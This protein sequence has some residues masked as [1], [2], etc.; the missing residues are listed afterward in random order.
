LID[1]IECGHFRGFLSRGKKEENAAA[2]KM[3]KIAL[4]L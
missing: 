2:P 4:Q 3:A 1:Y